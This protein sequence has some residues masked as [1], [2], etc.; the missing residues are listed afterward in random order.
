MV[1][2]SKLK[3]AGGI[4]HLLDIRKEGYMK[5]E[6]MA[7]GAAVAFVVVSLI[8]IRAGEKQ[9]LKDTLTKGMPFS[10]N[11]EDRRTFTLQPCE[12]LFKYC[13][14]PAGFIGWP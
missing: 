13:L 14:P 4:H 10:M 5:R 8:A 2:A 7:A 3:R 12:E 6:L 11:I 9:Y 1:E